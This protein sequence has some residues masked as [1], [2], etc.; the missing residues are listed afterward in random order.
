MPEPATS[1]TLESVLDDHP[2]FHVDGDGVSRTWQASDKVLRF[3]DANTGPGMR[4]LETGEGVSTVLFALKGCRHVAVT[5][6]GD[7]VKRIREYCAGGDISLA[8]VNFV[9]AP[10]DAVLPGLDT[11]ELDLVLVDGGHGFPLPFIDWHYLAPRLRDGGLLIVDDT[12]LWTGRV[13]KEFLL[14]EP[15]WALVEDFAPRAT[16][17][18]KTRGAAAGREWTDQPYV[19]RRSSRGVPG[20]ALT[21]VMLVRQGQ[22]RTLATMARRVIAYHAPRVLRRR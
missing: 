13:L 14:A 16:I 15:G 20:K 7:A 2:H 19:A 9:E 22:L 17:F 10:S 5:P 8:D 12:Q 4:T 6:N 3:I 21:S 1:R 11:G 18:R